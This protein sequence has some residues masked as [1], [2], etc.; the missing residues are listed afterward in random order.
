MRRPAA[1]HE[2]GSGLRTA[3]LDE[4]RGAVRAATAVQERF[5]TLPWE[6][7]AADHAIGRPT[8][9]SEEPVHLFAWLGI[10]L[11][12][13]WAVL[14]LGFKIVSGVVHLIVLV[15]IVLLVWGLMKKGARAVNNRL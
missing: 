3:A 12:V 5:L 7:A 2:F 10:A 4:V 15:G 14:W 11:V 13:L 1:D 6:R 9:F 8:I